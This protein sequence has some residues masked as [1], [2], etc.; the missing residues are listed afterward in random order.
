MINK[1]LT[2]K[3]KKALEH[4]GTPNE[5]LYIGKSGTGAYY[6]G[7]TKYRLVSGEDNFFLTPDDAIEAVVSGFRPQEVHVVSR[8]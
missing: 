5:R 7:N 8:D 6:V 3:L 1:T 2:K 4:R